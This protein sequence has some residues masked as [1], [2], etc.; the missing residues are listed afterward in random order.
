MFSGEGDLAF[1]LGGIKS[2]RVLRTIQRGFYAAAVEKIE[3][4][5]KPEDFFGHRKGVLY[6]SLWFYKIHFTD[7][8]LSGS[9]WGYGVI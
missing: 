3:D 7:E 9:L 8:G 2:E 5:R 1:P 4:Q 6:G